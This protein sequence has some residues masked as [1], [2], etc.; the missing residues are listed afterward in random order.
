MM[1]FLLSILATISIAG[2]QT[3]N[4]YAKVDGFRL[5]VAGKVILAI[6]VVPLPF[7]V[8]WP[9]DPFFYLFVAVTV[10]LALYG[11]KMSFDLAARYGGGVVS[12]VTP[13][14]LILI[15]LFWMVIQ[16][17]TALDYWEKPVIFGGIAFALAGAVYFAMQMRRCR[18]SLEALRECG[19]LIF[20]MAGIG[21]F[22]KLA[23]DHSDF[24]GGVYA[25]IFCNAALTAVVG[26]PWIAWT[27]IRQ[28]GGFSSA[29][30]PILLK[31]AFFTAGCI[32]L[33]LITKNYALKM[34]GDPT[35]P[36]AVMLT[37]PLWILL[38]YKITRHKEEALLW[39]GLG[40]A[41]CVMV[42]AVLREI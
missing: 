30:P 12:R 40:V 22:N 9:H 34:V 29:F 13:L 14:N 11:D 17:A 32:L 39:P 24:H 3:V 19:P 37:S 4:Q 18:V 5:A 20:A 2:I 31:S 8:G 7:M 10:P 15:F 28:K 21:I 23:M 42:L 36:S 33:H 38:F 41:G 27:G 25:Y 16:P 26:L 1:W 6:A 35:F